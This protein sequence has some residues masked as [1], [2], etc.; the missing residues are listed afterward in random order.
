MELQLLKP[1]LVCPKPQLA[2]SVDWGGSFLR[3]SYNKSLMIFGSILGP[4]ISGN[5]QLRSL[6][7]LQHVP[8]RT[9]F[10]SSGLWEG[11]QVRGVPASRAVK[12]GELPFVNLTEALYT[13]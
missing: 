4:L 9:T 13:W 12:G 11:L 2:V 6:Y 5:S 7:D 1:V 10:G 3:A 8:S